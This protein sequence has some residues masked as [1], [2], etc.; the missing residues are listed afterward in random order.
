M[1]Y[2]FGRSQATK[3]DYTGLQ[4]QTA[5]ATLPIPICYGKQ[6]LA[7]NVVFYANFR[8][9]NVKSGKGG[10]FSS[11]TTGYNYTADL[12]MAL[13]EGPI[14]NIGYI[15]RDQSTYTL[16]NLG[17]TLFDG[18]TP[19]AQWPY[20]ASTYPTEALAY[21]GT[22]YVCAANYQLGGAAD[23]GNHNFE[24]VGVLAGTGVNGVDADP[25]QVIYDFLT[26]AQYGA[27]FNPASIDLTTLYGSG[28]DASLQTYCKAMGIAFSPLLSSTEQA[29]SILT[30]W[31]Q[32]LNC[33]A[34]WSGG[35]LKFIPYGDVAI[36]AGN[37]SKVMTTPVPIPAQQSN[38]IYP[39]PAVVVSTAANFVADGGVAYA[40]TGVAL[41]YVGASAPTSTGQYGISP[42]GTYL[43]NIADQGSPVV[44]TATVH[45]PA[46]YT[47]NLTPVYSLTDLD[48]VDEKGGK[49]PVQASRVDPFS[50]PTIQRIECL[51][52]DNQYGSTP[53]EARDQSQIE[54]YGVRVGSTV[55]AHEIC[56]EIGI[57]PVIAQTILQRQLYVRTRYQFKLSWEYCLLDPMDIV[58]ITDSN[59]GLAAYP[60]RIVSLEEDD[61]GLITVTAEELVLGV[62]TP[63]ANP[64]N[65]VVA[66]TPNQAAAAP[67]INPPL[68][69]EPPPA[70]TNNIAQVWFGAS[71]APNTNWGGAYVWASVDNATYSQVGTIAAPLRQGVLTGALAAASGWDLTDTLNVSLSESG[72][73]LT[74][75][76]AASAQAGA[77]LSLVDSEL[78]AYETATLTGANAYA[79]TGLQRGLAGT[80]GAAH[81]SGAA[82]A[83]LD[84]AVAQY[85]LPPTWVGVPLYF[86]FQSFNSF[87]SGVQDLSTCAVYDY[88]PSGAGA[89]GPVTQALAIGTDL[90]WGAV[91]APVVE[92]DDWGA[93]VAAAPVAFIDLGAVTN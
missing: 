48:F 25:S 43:F 76:S 40:F 47:P 33:A 28:G 32:L 55:Q 57:G 69:Y 31:L 77:T 37:V 90:D 88:T 38:G 62:S 84:S 91:T 86:K 80:T 7:P 46:A 75:T 66:F 27:G 36:A 67:A 5:V 54:L 34:V 35:Q 72:G 30:R 74:G 56:D 81:A 29:S 63:G 4:L 68:I 1:A 45:Q 9:Q 71:G 87:G 17:L 14:S 23:V 92:S 19:Q 26:N 41:T 11:P 42:S 15:W 20:L 59:L 93:G 50:L 78:L 51:S 82:F 79:L 6:K 22:A 8:T 83:R 44:I 13:C 10:L 60:V 73:S 58:E 49:D 85:N 53:V 70:L 52:R 61:S 12:I 3:P 21:Q 2:L 18:T 89:L 16:A 65:G 64:A 39:P 24:V